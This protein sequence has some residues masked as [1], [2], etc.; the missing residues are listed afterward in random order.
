MPP[1]PPLHPTHPLPLHSPT[2][3]PF[4]CSTH[5]PSP[6][7]T[8]PTT[9]TH[10]YTFL[11][12]RLQTLMAILMLL[13]SPI[14]IPHSAWTAPHLLYSNYTSRRCLLMVWPLLPHTQHARLLPTPPLPV[15]T[16][17]LCCALCRAM[18]SPLRP[19]LYAIWASHADSARARHWRGDASLPFAAGDLSRRRPCCC[20]KLRGSVHGGASSTAAPGG[21]AHAFASLGCS[22]L[23]TGR[24]A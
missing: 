11:S 5:T 4:L 19:P 9:R 3:F 13:P 21:T 15:L 18:A 20:A 22:A 17:C 2:H 12:I 14:S 10:T 7:S 8:H 6:H 23:P 24:T 16:G 1:H